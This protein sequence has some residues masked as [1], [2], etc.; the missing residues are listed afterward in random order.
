MFDAPVFEGVD[1][2]IVVEVSV[3]AGRVVRSTLLGA[4]GRPVTF[5]EASAQLLSP[6]A[7]LVWTRM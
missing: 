5:V 3:L 7:R 2:E 6:M 1:Q 4:P